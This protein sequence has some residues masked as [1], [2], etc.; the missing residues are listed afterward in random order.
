M[1]NPFI[2]PVQI[3][4]S[5]FVHSAVPLRAGGI[6]AKRKAIG[7]IIER[8]NENKKI[9]IFTKHKITPERFHKIIV[10][11]EFYYRWRSDKNFGHRSTFLLP[12]SLLQKKYPL[13]TPYKNYMPNLHDCHA[14]SSMEPST[15]TGTEVL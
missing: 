9:I 6:G 5:S 3:Y 14:S 4:F 1:G 12:S 15:F 7:K 2:I 8:I 13:A 10:P 11:T